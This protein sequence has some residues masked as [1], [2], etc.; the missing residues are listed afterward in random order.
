MYKKKYE[1]QLLRRNG[2]FFHYTDRLNSYI[3]LHSGASKK[4]DGFICGNKLLFSDFYIKIKN[5]K[6]YRKNVDITQL[7]SDSFVTTFDEIN[8]KVSCFIPFGK[9]TVYIHIENPSEHTFK[10]VFVK[11]NFI[12]QQKTFSK[13][14]NYLIFEKKG[15][16]K[17]SDEQIKKEIDN[18]EKYYENIEKHLNFDTGI[19]FVNKALFWCQLSGL[20]LCTGLGGNIGIWA[21][22]P[23]F[24]ENWGR[25]TFIALQGILLIN[26]FFDE[27][28]QVLYSFIR[29]QKRDKA[30]PNYGRIPN[31]YVDDDDVV[32]NTADGNL[33]FIKALWQYIQY[34]GDR[35]FLDEIWEGVKLAVFCDL[36]LRTDENG[37]LM[38][39]DSDTWM[40]A[41]IEGKQ[42]LSAR[43]NRANDIQAM[44]YQSLNIF[45]KISEI[46]HSTDRCEEVKTVIE[47]L[48]KNFQNF[49]WNEEINIL[50]DRISEKGI[51][52]YKIRPNQLF[53]IGKECD[54]LDQK[55]QKQ[56]TKDCFQK[57]TLPHGVTS[58]SPLDEDFHPYHVGTHMY[59][60]DAAYHNGAIWLWL[61]G[62]MISSLCN[63]NWQNEAWKIT[64]NHCR[65]IFEDGCVGTLSE[66]INAVLKSGTITSTGTWS[67]AWSV[68][69]FSRSFYQDYLG[70]YPKLMEGKID[71][72]PRLP[73]EWQA[74]NADIFFGKGIMKIFWSN[75]E[76][77]VR[78]FTLCLEGNSVSGIDIEYNGERRTLKVGEKL[79]ITA[80]I[81]V[82]K[83]PL[84]F[85]HL[86]SLSSYASM[87]KKNYLFK[88]IRNEYKGVKVRE[89]IKND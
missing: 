89:V 41:R 29:H 70:V 47:K 48:S 63:F 30:S 24:K 88:K 57:L 4:D 83:E 77:G 22:L 18:T 65:Q 61:S 28:R 54:L 36:D 84:S 81:P 52:D 62:P 3:K 23:W 21:G 72:N 73:E 82:E 26:G 14:E 17:L 50:A 37:F 12:V 11:K 49:F 42:P 27:A 67:Q 31:R 74:G 6:Y 68:S 13:I 16:E 78:T 40:D 80:E 60:K 71:F 85:V 2:L 69:E 7:Y 34:T 20:N 56:I 35:A 51:A 10:F 39:Q 86:N 33:L 44:W 58:L 66:N 45:L 53:C 9:G 46:V 87:R 43:G 75:L 8:I 15:S 76:K 25:D 59:H 79:T 38:N 32:Y 64:K 5:K 1:I 19:T 55:I